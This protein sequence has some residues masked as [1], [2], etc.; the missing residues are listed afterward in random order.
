MSPNPDAEEEIPF[1]EG[2]ILKVYGD[3]DVDG[4]YRGEC[5]GKIGY[6]PCNMVSEVCVE[7]NKVKKDLLK[8]GCVPASTLVGNLGRG[9]EDCQPEPDALRTMVAIFDYNPRESSPNLDVEV[10]LPFTAGDIIT[11]L[12]CMDDDGFYYGE[13]NGQRGLVPSNFLEAV[14]LDGGATEGIHS[15][16]QDSCAP[17]AETQLNSFVLGEEQN[18]TTRTSKGSPSCS[19][20][21]GPSPEPAL[22]ESP[23]PSE[24]PALRKRK[25]SFFLKGRKLFK[26]L[27]FSKKD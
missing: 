24:V 4:F 12:G 6:I 22:E 19:T 1:K 14:P 3:K 23:E 25:R 27:G 7:N 13:V 16:D 8:Q 21:T 18:S 2:Q 10:E 11:V 15:K 20:S 9:Q 5:A 17:S 26:K